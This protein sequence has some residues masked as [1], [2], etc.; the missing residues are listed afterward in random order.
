MKDGERAVLKVSAVTYGYFKNDEYKV[1]ASNIPIAKAITPCKGDLL[2]SR[3]NTRELVGA[4]AIVD[5]DYPNLL[6][7]DKI[8]KLEVNDKVHPVFFKAYLSSDYIRKLLSAEASGT[9]GSMFNISMQKLR[10]IPVFVPA[11]EQ[12]LLFVSF[13]EQLDKSKYADSRSKEQAVA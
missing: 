13:M 4:T 2:F 7:P 6:L 10:Q 5:R 12:Q 3:A 9:S 8:W 1:I 11:M